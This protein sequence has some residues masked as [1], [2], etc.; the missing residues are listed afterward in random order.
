MINT[1]LLKSEAD[2]IGIILDDTALARLDK[3]AEM[4]VETN[5]TLNLSNLIQLH[6]S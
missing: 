6:Q 3:Y 5:K 4:I 1:T 2:K